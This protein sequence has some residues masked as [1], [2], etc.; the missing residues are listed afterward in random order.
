MMTQ[1]NAGLVVRFYEAVHNA[2][3]LTVLDTAVD[4]AVVSRWS[5]LP[6]MHSSAELRAALAADL[7]GFPDHSMVLDQVVADGN[8]VASRW[9]YRGTHTGEYYGIP[10][11][12]RSIVSTVVSFD[13]I[14]DGKLTENWVVFDTYDVMRQLGIVPDTEEAPA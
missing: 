5:G 6:E 8:D 14:I 9:T 3:D 2:H 1:D 12:G 13:R 4:S 11:T 7:E 10:A